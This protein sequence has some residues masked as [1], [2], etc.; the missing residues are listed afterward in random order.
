MVGLPRGGKSTWAKSQLYPIVSKDAIR[1]AL[2]GERYLQS[3]EYFVETLGQL[4]VKAMFHAGHDIVIAD[5]TNV[6][7]KRRDRWLNDEWTTYFKYI[8]TSKEVCI[9][10]ARDFLNDPDIIPIIEYMSSV[11]EPL[12]HDEKVYEYDETSEDIYIGIHE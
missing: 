8:D 5:E 9:L 1:L 6:T 10:R 2:H 4:M 11:F 12:E 7:R 3:A